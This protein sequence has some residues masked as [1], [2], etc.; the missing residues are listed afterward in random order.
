MQSF[1]VELFDD[2]WKMKRADMHIDSRAAPSL[3]LR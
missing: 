3:I 2:L 1:D